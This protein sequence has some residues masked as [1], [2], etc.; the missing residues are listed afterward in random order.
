M[1]K[2]AL[3]ES[4]KQWWGNGNGNAPPAGEYCGWG[5]DSAC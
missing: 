5:A 3:D 4:P 2:K 1:V